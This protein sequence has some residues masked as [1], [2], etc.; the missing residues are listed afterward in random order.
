M[1]DWSRYLYLVGAV[2]ALGSTIWAAVPSW[3]RS[4]ANALSIVGVFDW[5]DARRR[6]GWMRFFIVA[7][8]VLWLATYLWIASPFI[9][10]LIGG[11]AGGIFLAAV[12][13]AAWYLRYRYVEPEL[14]GGWFA[15]IALGVSAVAIL[16]LGVYS[17]LSSAGI[18]DVG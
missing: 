4:W 1:G 6:N 11:V 14:R 10:I 2:A 15:S 12:A 5:A 16:L 13:V 18:I 17:A 9:M 8:P 3:S 7:L